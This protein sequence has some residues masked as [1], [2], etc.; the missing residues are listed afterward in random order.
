MIGAFLL[1]VSALCG[2]AFGYA[3]QRGSI[4]AVLGVAEWIEKRSGR[5]LLAFLRCS[6]WVLA[7]AAPLVWIDSDAHLASLHR[8][9]IAAFVGGVLFGVG[10]SINGGCAYGTIN[11]LGAGE[12]SFVVT[13]IGMVA[14]FW[15]AIWAG[16][17]AAA[18]LGPSPIE[19]PSL[20]S[21]TLVGAAMMFCV[22]ELRI[23]HKGRTGD[24]GWSPE[25]AVALM[26]LS[27]GVLHVLH[28]GW[29]Y[30]AGLQDLAAGLSASLPFLLLIMTI[31]GAAIA[32]GKGHRFH[33][34]LD[35]KSM[36]VRFVGGVVMGLGG[37]WIPGGNDALVMHD[38]PAL[39]PHVLIAYPALIV[40]V[41]I[42]LLVSRSVASW[43]P[44]R[45][46]RSIV[47]WKTSGRE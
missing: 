44:R 30:M 4:C 39:S 33:L 40:G 5:H 19:T 25:R 12:I 20:L 8:P 18:S 3:A 29:A 45:A 41:A 28:G 16:V 17:M 34:R 7:V 47:S 42:G 38:A 35:A 37:A 13:L 14:G 1:I 11:R 10:A 31:V 23:M 36:P 6:V 2:I 32:A 21:V 27:G 9:S 43:M 24:P 22:R 15:L 26:G 46:L